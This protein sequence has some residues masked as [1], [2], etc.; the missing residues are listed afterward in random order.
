[1]DGCI[2]ED[3]LVDC[4]TNVNCVIRNLHNSN[5]RVWARGNV[6][7]PD[8]VGAGSQFAIANVDVMR[9]CVITNCV[10]AYNNGSDANCAFLKSV[11]RVENCTFAHNDYAYF[12]YKLNCLFLNTAIVGNWSSWKD[13]AGDV[14]MYYA[15]QFV[16][17]NCVWNVRG[18][19]TSSARAEPYVDGNCIELGENIKPKFLNKGEH[20]LTPKLN[21]PLVG[22]GMVMPWMSDAVDFA[23]NP[24]I[25]DGKVDI[26]AYQCWMTPLGLGLIFR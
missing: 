5:S 3:G 10:W 26:G 13:A 25:R 18:T 17:S 16:F 15:T 12:G 1:M 2:I 7:Y 22:A 6:Q 23:G 19:R 14:S 9:N 8:G 4:L 24:R 21:S 11:K 20:P